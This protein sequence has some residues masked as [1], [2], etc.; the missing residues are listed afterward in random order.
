MKDSRDFIDFSIELFDRRRV[1]YIVF[2]IILGFG[3]LF[4]SNNSDTYKFDIKVSVSNESMFTEIIDATNFFN[5]GVFDTSVNASN[6]K[7]LIYANLDY[8]KISYKTIKTDVCSLIKFSHMNKFFIN[9]V[10]DAYIKS[11]FYQD[12]ESR[13]S[14]ASKLAQSITHTDHPGICSLVKISTATPFINFLER[15]YAGL[16]NNYASQEL[17]ARILNIKNIR[18]LY[19]NNLLDSSKPEGVGKTYIINKLKLYEKVDLTGFNQDFFNFQKS[20]IASVTPITFLFYFILF[21]SIVIYVMT[22][23]LIDFWQQCLLRKLS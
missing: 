18:V 11:G 12:S 21:L 3:L 1:F 9:M 16:L 22:I 15:D 14:I 10:A 13:A 20:K 5:E 19:M 17:Y 6:N 7:S 8:K 2:I 4:A 23:I